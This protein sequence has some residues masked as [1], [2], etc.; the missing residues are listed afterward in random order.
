MKESLLTSLLLTVSIWCDASAVSAKDTLRWEPEWSVDFTTE[1]QLTHRGKYNFAN[2]LR[3][4]ASLPIGRSLS[5][6]IGSLST[7]MT[8]RESI[9]GDLQVFSNLDAEDIPFALS[10]CGLNWEINSRHSLFLG[11]RNMNED[12]FTSPVTSLFTASS[13]GIFP[14]ISCN[15]DIAN[16]PLASIGAHYRYDNEHD[17]QQGRFAFQT[18]L[19]N[20]LGSRRFAGRD[21]IFRF[22]PQSDGLFSLTQVDYHYRGGSYFLGACGHYGDA[23]VDGKHRFGTTLWAYTEQ[24]ITESLSLMAACSH[25]FGSS[26]AC[27]DFAGIGGR[28]AWRRCE[29]GLF[30]DYARFAEG[31]ESATEFTCKIQFNPHIYLQPSAHFAFTPSTTGGTDFCSMALLRLGVSF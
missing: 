19:Y 29:F 10:L 28:Y 9:G 17:S 4:Q 12:Y 27:S 23:T 20:G 31:G 5:F 21:N 25:A 2:L 6:D 14:T 26:A 8:R 18:S 22:C 30:T 24:Q 13:C 16:Y 15:Y 7:Y 3:L 1:Q 11:I